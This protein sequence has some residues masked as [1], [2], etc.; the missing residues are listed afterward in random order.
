M[1]EL[2]IYDSQGSPIRDERGTRNDEIKDFFF[3]GVRFALDKRRN[4]IVCFFRARDNETARSEQYY[5]VYKYANRSEMG[6]IVSAVESRIENEYGMFLDTSNE[7]TEF[8]EF[9]SSGRSSSA[10][11]DMNTKGD[12]GSLLSDYQRVTVGVGSYSDA[13]GLFGEFWQNDGVNTV[14]VSDNAS[15]RSVSS[16]DLVIEKGD[17]RGLE[18]IGDTEA[19]IETLRERRRPDHLAQDSGD[20]GGFLGFNPSPIEGALLFAAIGV[21]LL[22]GAVYATCFVGNYTIPGSEPLP[23][24]GECG[25]EQPRVEAVNAT[26]S[27]EQPGQLNVEGNLSQPPSDGNIRL[28]LA[29]A[30]GPSNNGTN[31]SDESNQSV[32]VSDDGTF[33]FTKTLDNNTEMDAGVYDAT[34]SYANS[35]KTDTFTVTRANTGVL[36]Q[37]DAQAVRREGYLTMRITGT[38]TGLSN[39]SDAAPLAIEITNETGALFYENQTS[40]T[41]DA[42][43]NFIL[44]ADSRATAS[45]PPGNYTVNVTYNGTTKQSPVIVESQEQTGTL[46]SVTASEEG[47]DGNA[48]ISISG[49]I[50]GLG[51]QG[52]ASGVSIIVTN[53][54]GEQFHQRRTT[55]S[56]TD[57]GTFTVDADSEMTDGGYPNGSYNVSVS[58]NRTTKYDDVT[59]GTANSS[60][61]SLQ[62]VSREFTP[63]IDPHW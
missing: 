31:Y 46:E 33:A 11:G 19:A 15:G 48:T 29:V 54:T 39:Q 34:V 9:L 28:H 26:M 25:V 13:Y 4:E 55:V 56:V 60:T 20:D 16:Y 59:I 49:T 24:I 38:I 18:P 5:A 53:D 3:D 27:E 36:E 35:N 7:D 21:L 14:A 22:V 32:N 52:T 45:Y 47:T 51:Q 17:Y 41:T 63:G 61:S 40:V 37:I 23:G 57:N 10:P 62:P 1:A 42:D 30:P 12:I 6:D 43:G 44:A 8:F 2:T 50:S 58:Y